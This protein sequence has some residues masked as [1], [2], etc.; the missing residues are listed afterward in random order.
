MEFIL[1]SLFGVVIVNLFLLAMEKI[2][3]TNY[4]EL[5]LYDVDGKEHKVLCLTSVI[6]GDTIGYVSK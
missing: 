1:G 2:S 3:M 4:T 5:T 6:N